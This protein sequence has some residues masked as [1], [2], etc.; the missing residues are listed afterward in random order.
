M[1]RSTYW[2]NMLGRFGYQPQPSTAYNFATALGL[3]GV[4]LAVG[5]GVGMLMAPKAG[6]ELRGDLSRSAGRLTDQIRR[7]IPALSE[8]AN[9]VYDRNPSIG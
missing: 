2:N 1:T 4:G 8:E 7:R 3:L 5:T 6:S 9:H